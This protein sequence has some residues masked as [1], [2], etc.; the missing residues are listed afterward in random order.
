MDYSQAVDLSD[1]P[2]NTEINALIERAA[3]ATMELPRSYLGAS[4]LGHECDRQVQFDWWVQP[5]LPARVKTIFARGHFFEAL[6]HER[7]IGAGFAFAPSEALEFV[8]LDGYLQG[9]ADGVVIAA[10]PLPGVYLATPC[11]WEC[12]ALNG[13]NWRAVSRDGLAK[14]F[15]RYSVQ[16]SLYQRFLDKTNPALV[17][18]VNA[19]TCEALHFALAFNPMRARQAVDRAIAI[20][21]ATRTG[22]LL[23]SFT[24]DPNDWRCAICSHRERCWR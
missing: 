13:K 7:L 8:A 6:M 2:L 19:D 9:H 18:C 1:E 10:P 3:A 5:L 11:V 16:I 22:E 15:P 4:I 14:V 17:T 21:A 24:T 20:I 23:P 12:K